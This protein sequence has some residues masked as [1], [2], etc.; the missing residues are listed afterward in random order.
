MASCVITGTLLDPSETAVA[1]ATV[2]F[3]ICTPNFNSGTS[4]FVP[5][6]ISVQ[7][8]TLGVFTV[9]LAQGLSVVASILYPPNATDSALRTNYAFSVP[10][11]T[12]AAFASLVTEF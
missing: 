1:S 6:E 2:R 9:T 8:N 10:A 11:T 3:N 4:L 12:T 5:K 7:T